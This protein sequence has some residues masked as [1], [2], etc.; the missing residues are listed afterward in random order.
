MPPK[1]SSSAYLAIGISW[2]TSMTET[3]ESQNFI[4]R[5]PNDG[6]CQ[7]RLYDVRALIAVFIQQRPEG[8][9]GHLLMP[10]GADQY[11]ADRQP[12]GGVGDLQVDIERGIVR[13]GQCMDAA[14]ADGGLGGV[15]Q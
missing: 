11:L 10:A 5:S 14:G 8:A 1:P 3:S 15:A 4:E 9:R 7:R 12:V 2:S 6:L 13:L